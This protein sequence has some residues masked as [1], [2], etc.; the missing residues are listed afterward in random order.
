MSVR[1]EDVNYIVDRELRR[2]L[3]GEH[4]YSRNPEGELADLQKL[5]RD[6]VV[7][8]WKKFARP[9]ACTIYFAGDV[10]PERAFDLVQQ[11]LG[12]WKVEGD[13]P[14]IKL[15]ELP[16]PDQTRIYLVDKPGAVQSQVRVGQ[17]SIT[18][19]DPT[20]HY[21]RFFT[22]IYGG[23]FDSRLNKIIRIQRGL[24]YGAG[25]GFSAQRF[26]G[27]FI[28]ETFTKTESTAETVRA[29]LDVIKSMKDSPPTD[30]E[31]NTARAYLTGSFP[32]DL[33][34]PQ[35]AANY[36]WLIEYC[37]LSRD[38]L[39]QAMQSYKNADKKDVE[40]VADELVKTDSLTI[41]VAGEAAK[42]REELEKIAPVTVVE[43]PAP[44]QDSAP[45][46]PAAQPAG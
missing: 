13:K 46:Q 16:K 41:V 15:P 5:T 20:Y 14:H 1:E 9:D 33:E 2:R 31:M 19:R 6:T 34:T 35:D 11:H 12:T 17:L 24:T 3:H 10:E 27:R 45:P 37:G 43:A 22:Q 36:Q 7:A 38:Y 4:P 8:F 23:A 40:R 18:R 39:S 32:S 25:G 26:A 21:A 44:V 28:S 30:E 29:I 42:I